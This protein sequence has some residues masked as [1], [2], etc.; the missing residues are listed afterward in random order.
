MAARPN[1]IIDQ[2][3]DTEH[4]F[5]V[6]QID[7]AGAYFTPPPEG[8]IRPSKLRR[9]GSKMMSVLRTLTNSGMC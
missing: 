5:M 1:Y 6:E 7:K 4:T 3:S 9:Q 2:D 8:M